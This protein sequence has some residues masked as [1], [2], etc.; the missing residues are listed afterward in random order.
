MGPTHPDL[1]SHLSP[2]LTKRWPHSLDSDLQVCPAHSCLSLCTHHPLCFEH[3]VPASLQAGPL[4]SVV[5]QVSLPWPLC[6]ARCSPVPIYWDIFS[7]LYLSISEIIFK[8]Q[9]L[10]LLHFYVY[11][12][13]HLFIFITVL[14]YYICSTWTGIL[15]ILLAAVSLMP[16]RVLTAQ[17]T[18]TSHLL[19]E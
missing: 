2:A 16:E 13:L 1:T 4:L 17:E 11:L 3:T 12:Y 14:L 19:N 8:L 5:S 15:L 9:F 6:P 18:F 10:F 7:L